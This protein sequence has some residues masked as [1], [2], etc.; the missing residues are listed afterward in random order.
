MDST[1]LRELG[2]DELR[3]RADF[4]PVPREKF[5]VAEGFQD[6]SISAARQFGGEEER[7]LTVYQQNVRAGVVDLLSDF[8]LP[9]IAFASP[10]RANTTTPI[11][12][13]TLLNYSF[14]L[15]MSDSLALRLQGSDAIDAVYSLAFQRQPTPQERETVSKFVEKYGMVAFCRAILN[16]NELIYLE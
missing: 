15:D 2:H 1:G 16:S 14:M 13:L 6:G 8:D 5:K 12:S 3:A 10:R 4:L 7:F 9:D 11:Q